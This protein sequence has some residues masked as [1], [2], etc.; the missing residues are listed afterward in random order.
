MGVFRESVRV[1]FSD[2]A[3]Y[4]RVV[5]CDVYD[6]VV[7]PLSALVMIALFC[8]SF[9]CMLRSVQLCLLAWMLCGVMLVFICDSFLAAGIL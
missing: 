7:F 5:V 2:E 4:F 8:V 6:A 3:L 1:V 9:V